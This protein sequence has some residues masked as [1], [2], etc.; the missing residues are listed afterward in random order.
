MLT[1]ARNI[2]AISEDAA[3]GTVLGTFSG[4]EP[5]V[6]I[7]IVEQYADIYVGGVAGFLQRSVDTFRIEGNTLVLAE[8]LDYGAYDLFG[9]NYYLEFTQPGSRDYAG[10]QFSVEDVLHDQGGTAQADTLKG[11]RGMDKLRGNGGNDLL[12]GQ[13]GEDTL[14][15]GAG[16]DKLSG[17]LQDD[18]F[19]YKKTSESTTTSMD[20]ITDFQHIKDAAG[21]TIDLLA[22]DANTKLAGNQEFSWLGAKSF[23]GKAGQLRFEESNGNAYVYADTNGDKHADF[24]IRVDHVS[25]LYADDFIL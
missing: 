20:R 18:V 21:D 24:A 8:K 19:L 15:G 16:A 25:K 5:G 17:G 13:R 23:T 4:G 11:D 1:F 22:I 9:F 14:Y 10:T 3:V 6:E 12:Y 7:V 2:A